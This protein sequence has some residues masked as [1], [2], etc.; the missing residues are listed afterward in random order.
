MKIE[1][2]R[3]VYSRKPALHAVALFIFLYGSPDLLSYYMIIYIFMDQL[4]FCMRK[5][6]LRSPT[7]L[8]GAMLLSTSSAHLN[9]G[10]TGAP[11]S[12]ASAGKPPENSRRQKL[13]PRPGRRSVPAK[14]RSKLSVG[15]SKCNMHA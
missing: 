5:P 11:D 14:Q 8:L 1:E 13:R 10:P 6:K 2:K 12:Y 4:F 15:K 9:R 3:H 7:G